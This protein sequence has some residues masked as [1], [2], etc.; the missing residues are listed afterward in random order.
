MGEYYY[1]PAGAYALSFYLC[2]WN[3]RAHLS[4]N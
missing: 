2:Y 3:K 4:K 1:K